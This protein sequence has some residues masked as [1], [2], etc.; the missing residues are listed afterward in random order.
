M[1]YKLIISERAE[2]HIDNIID[3][4][5]DTLKNP[6]AAKAILS[7]IEEAYDKL[8]YMADV[9]GF[10][11]D[12]YLAE[13]GYRKIFLSNHDYLIIYRIEGDEARI[14][15]VFHMREEYANKL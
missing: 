7:D 8:E 6:G 13:R 5:V 11:N 9:L 2:R 15:G 4:V 14:S 10:C 12:Y 1:G 3:Y